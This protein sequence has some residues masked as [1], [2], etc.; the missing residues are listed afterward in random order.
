MRVN[1]LGFKLEDSD[2]ILYSHYLVDNENT[3]LLTKILLGIK[4]EITEMKEEIRRIKYG[5]SD[6]V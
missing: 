5:C 4:T 2:D 6:E 3:E 1:E